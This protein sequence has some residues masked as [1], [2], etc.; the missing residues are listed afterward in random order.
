[1]MNSNLFHEGFQPTQKLL[2]LLKILGMKSEKEMTLSS[3]NHWA[4]KNLLRR[5]E[6]WHEQSQQFEDLKLIIKLF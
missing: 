5:N 2:Q 6:R 4:Q 3:I 1:M